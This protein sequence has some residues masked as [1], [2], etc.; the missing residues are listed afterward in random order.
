MSRDCL[1][2]V[3]RSTIYLLA[4][5]L[6]LSICYMTTIKFCGCLCCSTSNVLLSMAFLS[7][8]THK[9]R[10]PPDC[11][12]ALCCSISMWIVSVSPMVGWSSARLASA[13]PSHS[14]RE[15]M[16]SATLPDVNSASS[17]L[18]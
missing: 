9:S 3:T 17:N 12:P 13:L 10:Y 18:F 16:A 14:R 15:L 4:I 2:R 7:Y 1:S 6:M 11:R 5:F 8:P